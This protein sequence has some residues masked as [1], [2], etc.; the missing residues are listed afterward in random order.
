MNH[1]SFNHL[2]YMPRS[3]KLPEMLG[4]SGTQKWAQQGECQCD[5]RMDKGD[6]K[7]R[8]VKK[9]TVI[10]RVKSIFSP[11]QAWEA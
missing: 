1:V 7:Q 4:D 6:E 8:L 10:E 5:E 11:F 9:G 2:N 3:A